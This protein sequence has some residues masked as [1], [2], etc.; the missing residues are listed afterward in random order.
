[1]P[2]NLIQPVMGKPV[3]SL[4]IEMDRQGV[5]TM[6]AQTV[7]PFGNVTAMPPLLIS[8][9]LSQMLTTVLGDIWRAVQRSQG[10]A[11]GNEKII[12]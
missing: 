4:V 9:L 8:S 2:E 10:A 1:M 6:K 7:D 12:T 5:S 3:H 11:N